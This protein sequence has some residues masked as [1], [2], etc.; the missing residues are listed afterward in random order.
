MNYSL[1]DQRQAGTSK[2][3]TKFPDLAIMLLVEITFHIVILILLP[4]LYN[5]FVILNRLK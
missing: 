1:D 2:C 5:V 3:L 4:T